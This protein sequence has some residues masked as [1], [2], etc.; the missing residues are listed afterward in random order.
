MEFFKTTKGKITAVF[1]AVLCIAA[2][3]FGIVIGTRDKNSYRTISVSELHGDVRVENNGKVYDAYPEMNLSDGYALFTGADSYTRMVLDSDKYIKLEELSR[4]VFEKLGKTGDNY[5]A[6]RLE[7]G[8]ITNEIA[9]PLPKGAEYTVN[10]PNAAMAV[11]G[12]FF[13]VK[14]VEDENG[15]YYTDI[16]T[17][18]GSVECK[19]I[20]PD[21]TVVNETVMVEAGFKTRIKMDS[22]D[23]IYLVEMFDDNGTLI[24]TTPII[25]SEDISDEDLIDMFDAAKNGHKMFLSIEEIEALIIE[26][27]IDI[28]KYRSKYDG[29][30]LKLTGSYTTTSVSSADTTAASTTTE[31]TTIASSAET[32]TPPSSVESEQS[33]ALPSSE[34]VSEATTKTARTTTKTEVTVRRTEETTSETEETVRRT[35]KTTSETEETVKRTEKTTKKTEK[36]TKKTEKTTKKTTGTEAPVDESV[37]ENTTVSAAEVTITTVAVTSSVP[38]FTVPVTITA[39]TS[40]TTSAAVV[41]GT[42]TEHECFFENY[43]Y[44][45]DATCSEDGT[46][47]GSCSCG[48][49]DTITAEGTKTAHTEVTESKGATF[50]ESGYIRVYCGTCDEEISYEVIEKLSPLNLSQGDIVI[51]S[52]GYSQSDGEEIGFTGDYLFA[53][54]SASSGG[55]ITVQSGTHNIAFENVTL[56]V[57]DMDGFIVESGATAVLSGNLTVI[58]DSSASGSYAL[59]NRG[60]IEFASGTFSFEAGEGATSVYNAGSIQLTDGTLNTTGD[61]TNT[62]GVLTVNGGALTVD[63]MFDN[64][65]DAEFTMN[66]G[67]FSSDDYF[68]ND[69]DSIIEINDG[70]FKVVVQEGPY[71]VYVNSGS[72]TVNGGT[73]EVSSYGYGLYS[74]GNVYIN[75]G[76]ITTSGEYSSLT[77][78]IGR[79]EISGGSII[80]ETGISAY[81]DIVMTGGSLRIVN[82]RVTGYNTITNGDAEVNCVCYDALPD[83]AELVFTKSDG[84]SYVYG[85]TEADTA[86][87]GKYYLWLPPVAVDSLSVTEPPEI[88]E[89]SDADYDSSTGT[90]SDY[91]DDT[92]I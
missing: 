56:S 66:G 42:I 41:T 30:Q 29:S 4:A 26:R 82:G 73:C 2:V 84:T 55:T 63:G 64:I 79:F 91:T 90:F 48:E 67:S 27:G 92:I 54:E 21:G 8:V 25:V 76:R 70:S 11:R 37:S 1:I 45:N 57:S 86:D 49:T 74:R 40:E 15:D 69:G 80:C 75:G 20:L 58:S 19:R 50:Y 18:G 34:Y 46:M 28:E 39:E 43:V 10:T 59:N 13:R 35:E 7:N 87:D 51:S 22:S 88:S 71:C 68:G 3:I 53:Q 14:T 6:I 17:Y 31:I 81:I 16:F 52:T 83:A 72:F 12:T 36:T 89:V 61:F 9:K 32:T 65:S 77:A 24:N 38:S 5:T 23:T 47:T 44:N 78:D 85:I 33:T 62:G 60:T